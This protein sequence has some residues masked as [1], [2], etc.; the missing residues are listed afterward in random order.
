MKGL[1]LCASLHRVLNNKHLVEC[2]PVGPMTIGQQWAFQFNI[3]MI[4]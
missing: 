1:A 2:A 3:L 4:H